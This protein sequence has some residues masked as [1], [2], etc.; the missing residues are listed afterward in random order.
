MHG[1]ID[2]PYYQP[3]HKDGSMAGSLE[4]N[5]AFRSIQ[6]AIDWGEEHLDLCPENEDI[7]IREYCN[8]EIDG[9]QLIDYHGNPIRKIEELSDKEITELITNEILLDAGS[10]DNLLEAKQSDETVR[11]YTERLYEEAEELV[12]DTIDS[13]EEDNE[14]DFSSFGGHPD[15]D[16]YDRAHFDAIE[17]VVKWMSGKE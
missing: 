8:D 3:Q 7:E 13:I 1:I 6:E 4:P 5:Q 12:D 9:V 17:Q 2:Y 10:I 14:Y 16:W 11:E 15:N